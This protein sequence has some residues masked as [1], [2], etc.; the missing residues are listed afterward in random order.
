V[1]IE[2]TVRWAER[3][4]RGRVQVIFLVGALVGLVGAG[5]VTTAFVRLLD[6]R[7]Q[8][9]DD[10]DPAGFVARDWFAA[11]VSQETGLR[12][13]ALTA[14][15]AFL[16]PYQEGGAQ[17]EALL[18][19]LAVLVA[20]YPEQVRLVAA[21]DGAA[22]AWQEASAPLVAE[23]RVLGA[24]AVGEPE[25]LEAK[26]RFDEVRLSYEAELADLDVARD[27]ARGQLDASTSQLLAAGV[28]VA[29][30][31]VAGAVAVLV[32]LRRWVLGPVD[33][34][35]AG[36]RAVAAGGLDRAI[37]PTGPPDLR[38]LGHDV[39]A[40][41]RRIVEELASVEASRAELERQAAELGRSNEE[42]EQFAYVA[43]HDL[44]EP[45][46]KV[47]GFCQLLQ[48]RYAGQLDETADEYI[49][50]AVDGA[51]RMQ[52]LINDLLAFSRVGR[53]N[54]ELVEVD[55][56]EVASAA[57]A[58]LGELVAETGAT[59]T[60]GQLPTVRGDRSLLGSL[61]Q[62]LVSNAIKFR[63]DDPP[64]VAVDA[65]RTAEGW[66]L[67]CHDEGIGIDP[68]YAERVFVI[69]QRL[70]GRDEYEGTGIGLAMCRKIVEFHGGRIWV[71]PDVARGTTIRWTLPARD[72][73]SQD[74]PPA[75]P[76]AAPE[77]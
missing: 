77:P 45:L 42:L 22:R 56:S 43:S 33:E 73:P 70:H 16:V 4:L 52:A 15:P 29:V 44:Q 61:V 17:A 8:V 65:R 20:D 25:L 37:E 51:K 71:D 31:L 19:E 76:P 54:D 74:A 53:G 67:W 5:L 21:L 9:V 63:G 64:V 38:A 28:V 59:V 7:E 27:A 2:A 47:T 24:G 39:E 12:G 55:L 35:A 32:N 3:G 58:G 10:L 57:L 36:A 6:A 14:D 34:L 13:Y 1:P 72:G 50:F 48:R 49:A 46:R 23:V 41:R 69:F 68:R 66:E 26:A 18:D 30:V 60:V 11:L 75:E 40:M 62:N